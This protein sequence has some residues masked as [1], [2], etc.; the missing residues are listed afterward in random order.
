VS[1]A[2]VAS[3][4]VEAICAAIAD[5]GLAVFDEFLPSKAVAAMAADARQRESAEEFHPAGVGRGAA[6]SELPEIRGDRICWLDPNDPCVALRPWW[7]A[8][9]ALRIALNETLFLGLWSFEGHYALYPA[10]SFYRRH[11]DRFHDHDARVL[12]CALYLNESW[13]IGEGGALRLYRN[14]GKLDVAPR[15]GTLVC[16]L[17]DRFEHEVLPAT[18][19][20]LA[21]TGWF[22]RRS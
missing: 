15:G 13:R 3:S 11:R 5:E 17:A 14:A 19:D 21:L 8:L 4:A 12:S 6:R 18:R 2:A 16:F 22:L 1:A 9:S 7:L 20:R 10:G